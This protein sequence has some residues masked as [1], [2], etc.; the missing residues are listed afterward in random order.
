[1]KLA[2][3]KPSIPQSETPRAQ[4]LL[5]PAPLVVYLR[6]SPSWSE[7]SQA[8]AQS[9]KTKKKETQ[10]SKWTERSWRH[11]APLTPWCDAEV[12]A[13]CS[14]S[15]MVQERRF[16]TAGCGRPAS[17]CRRT[18]PPE[19]R[20]W[21]RSS[22]FSPPPRQQVR[23]GLH[24][25]SHDLSIY[26]SVIVDDVL[27]FSKWDHSSMGMSSGEMKI[28]KRHTCLFG[29]HDHS[30]CE[31]CLSLMNDWLRITHITMCDSWGVELV[32]VQQ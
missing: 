6:V 29:D 24:C 23:A 13:R 4:H 12:F 26:L 15:R 31:C 5:S 30:C 19:R 17:F 3:R 1:M 28:L 8:W 7:T 14:R 10:N 32:T 16:P 21:T 9:G 25:R 22:A 11:L 2:Q 20:H 18:P 27:T